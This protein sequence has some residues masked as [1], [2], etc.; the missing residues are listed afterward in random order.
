MTIIGPFEWYCLS[1]N[2]QNQTIEEKIESLRKLGSEEVTLKCWH[3][4]THSKGYVTA[5]HGCKVLGKVCSSSEMH[6]WCI[7]SGFTE[8]SRHPTITTFWLHQYQTTMQFIWEECLSLIR[9]ESYR[10]SS[11][12]MDHTKLSNIILL[13]ILF[14]LFN[15]LHCVCLTE[16][17]M[18]TNQPHNL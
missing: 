8:D 12:K 10:D 9:Q 1:E 15:T 17:M 13:I 6:H 14:T 4:I 3:T 5:C 2:A 11:P 16:Y 18:F 7:C